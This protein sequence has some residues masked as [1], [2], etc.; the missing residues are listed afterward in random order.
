MKNFS[1]IFF[2]FIIST[3]VYADPLILSKSN[4]NLLSYAGSIANGKIFIKNI[5]ESPINGMSINALPNLIDIKND[6]CPK[7]LSPLSTCD[8]NI[9]FKS[10][11]TSNKFISIPITIT[12]TDRD[13]TDKMVVNAESLPEN[14]FYQPTVQGT[15]AHSINGPILSMVELEK[16]NQGI[17]YVGTSLGL[18][19]STD[20]GQN[21]L[22]VNNNEL[23]K[24]GFVA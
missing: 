6:N 7:S 8:Y 14:Y 9:S 10:S 19:K 16:N 15:D 11:D 20:N 24:T 13:S 22:L 3:C 2:T 23:S 18:F 17:L 21:W 1:L 4:Y 5:G 12:V